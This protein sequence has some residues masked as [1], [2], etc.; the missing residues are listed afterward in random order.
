[1]EKFKKFKLYVIL[2]MLYHTIN[3]RI[4][5][6]HNP[7]FKIFFADHVK[8]WNVVSNSVGF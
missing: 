3:M 8:R 7:N 1:M 2:H 4:H 5:N 6:V